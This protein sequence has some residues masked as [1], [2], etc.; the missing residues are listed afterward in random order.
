M[1]LKKS[2]LF[3]HLQSWGLPQL[4]PAAVLRFLLGGG[5]VEMALALLP[6]GLVI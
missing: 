4:L 6:P 2:M 1:K 3:I 5:P